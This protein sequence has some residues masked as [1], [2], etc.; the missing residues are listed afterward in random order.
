MIRP[1]IARLLLWLMCSAAVPASASAQ[2]LSNLPLED[3]M[4][5]DSGQVFGAS[6]RLQPSTEAPASVSFVT[7]AEI[8][9]FGYRTLADI[10]RGE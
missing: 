7:R 3:L 1:A 4:A 2:S 5:L 10:L 8:S 9:R 6:E